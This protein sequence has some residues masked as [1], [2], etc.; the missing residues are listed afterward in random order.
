MYAQSHWAGSYFCLVLV[1]DNSIGPFFSQ[2]GFLQREVQLLQLLLL[3]ENVIIFRATD[4]IPEGSSFTF[5]KI[6]LQNR[7]FYETSINLRSKRSNSNLNCFIKKKC[8]NLTKLLWL[9][10]AGHYLKS[11]RISPQ[12][13]PCGS[14]G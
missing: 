4:V 14:A 12:V 6:S 2:A 13:I 1:H 7:E 11:F 5:T 9:I 10:K 3:D 8:F